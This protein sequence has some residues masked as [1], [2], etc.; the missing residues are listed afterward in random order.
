MADERLDGNRVVG[1]DLC[2]VERQ[3][4]NHLMDGVD[5]GFGSLYAMAGLT[6]NTYVICNVTMLCYIYIHNRNI[7]I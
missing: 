5:D 2:G 6:Y 7:N 3:I 1:C 4:T